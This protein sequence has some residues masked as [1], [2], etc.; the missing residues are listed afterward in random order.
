VS[1]WRRRSEIV[2]GPRLDLQ[3]VAQQDALRECIWQE[4]GLSPERSWLSI[5]MTADPRWA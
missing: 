3:T 1:D 4:L 5:I 2:V